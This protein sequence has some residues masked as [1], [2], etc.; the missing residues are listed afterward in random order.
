M[1]IEVM[2]KDDQSGA[3]YLGSA[4]PNGSRLNDLTLLIAISYR[5]KQQQ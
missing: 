2:L 1:G 5:I 4:K 3:Y